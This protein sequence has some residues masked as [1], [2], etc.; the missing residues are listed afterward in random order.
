[1]VAYGHHQLVGR[2]QVVVFFF[3]C[4]VV[5]VD[6]FV[7]FVLVVLVNFVV[8]FVLVVFVVF[9]AIL[10]L[11]GFVAVVLALLILQVVLAVVGFV[12][13]VA[14]AILVAYPGKVDQYVVDARRGRPIADLIYAAEEQFAGQLILL[15]L[16][17]LME[18]A[19]HIILLRR[20]VVFHA[21]R[22]IVDPK[23]YLAGALGIGIQFGEHIRVGFVLELHHLACPGARRF[24]VAGGGGLV[25][26]GVDGWFRQGLVVHLG[27]LVGFRLLAFEEIE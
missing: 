8:I 3:E 4:H 19:A 24:V 1:M 9:V 20:E 18:H 12:L 13:I 10:I 23:P 6:F 7:I 17:E 16:D 15:F 27:D 26:L 25:V 22:H 5:L 2:P 14:I 21:E 11:V